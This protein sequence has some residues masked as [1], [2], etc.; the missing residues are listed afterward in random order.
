MPGKVKI[1]QLKDFIA[2][3]SHAIATEGKPQ[4][5]KK[6]TPLKNKK[7]TLQPLSHGKGILILK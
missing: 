5:T 3:H 1:N 4:N 2:M 6:V 7:L